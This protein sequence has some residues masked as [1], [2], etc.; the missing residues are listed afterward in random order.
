MSWIILSSSGFRE[1]AGGDVNVS[2]DDGDGAEEDVD[3][4]MEVPLELL[5]LELASSLLLTSL[6]HLAEDEFVDDDVDVSS[7]LP[8]LLLLSE[9]A[10]V[11]LVIIGTEL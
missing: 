7:S 3:V 6:R 10:A 5:E 8:N 2:E 11:D 9:W 4:D 1:S